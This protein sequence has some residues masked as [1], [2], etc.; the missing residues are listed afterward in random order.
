MQH[1]RSVQKEHM[2]FQHVLSDVKTTKQITACR[3]LVAVIMHKIPHLVIQILFRYRNE[4]RNKTYLLFESFDQ[5]L[6]AKI[7]F[8]SCLIIMSLL[9]AVTDKGHKKLI[10]IVKCI[11]ELD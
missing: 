2:I 8:S 1:I 7:I 3:T 10:N 9:I 5:L 4:E 6:L 11:C